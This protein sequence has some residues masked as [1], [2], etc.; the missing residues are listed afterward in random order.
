MELLRLARGR[1]IQQ[2]LKS[3]PFRQG[4]QQ[5]QHTSQLS[6]RSRPINTR[7]YSRYYHFQRP[8]SSSFTR[9]NFKRPLRTGR[10]HASTETAQP[11]QNLTLSQR[12]KKLS[13]EYGWTAV[14]VYFA[15]SALDFP[16]C[17]IAVRMLGTERI[18]H[19]EHVI[20]SNVKSVL[21]WPLPEAA[22]QQIEGPAE[23][24]E[25][26]VR[27]TI[28]EIEQ[29]KERLLDDDSTYAVQDHGVKAAQVANSG[30][31][32]SMFPFLFK[33]IYLT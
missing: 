9:T 5:Q 7:T 24:V 2:I 11:E 16:F 13:R 33:V 12:L 6:F 27:S 25:G 14:G 23:M 15:L 8:N 29:D 4:L 18:G 19:W 32:A 21:K 22:K 20:V 17:F 10:R 30:D 26:A 3:Q 28:N 1:T 31:N